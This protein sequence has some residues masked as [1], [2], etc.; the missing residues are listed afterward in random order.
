M[1]ALVAEQRSTPKAAP[2]APESSRHLVPPTIHEGGRAR[3]ASI[4]GVPTELLTLTPAFM[5]ALRKVAPK[6]R[7]SKIPYV[8][9]LGVLAFLVMLGADASTREFGLSKLAALRS[10]PAATPA[11]APAPEAVPTAVTTLTS[12]EAPTV[13]TPVANLPSAPVVKADEPAPAPAPA[14][15]AEAS[16]AK[17]SPA[18]TAPAAQPKKAQPRAASRPAS[19]RRTAMVK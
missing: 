14:P 16:T 17:K 8:I 3:L 7:R 4:S 10:T 19:Q 13:S 12:A 18:K 6:K 2:K 11:A 9:A 5:D 1:L 15:A